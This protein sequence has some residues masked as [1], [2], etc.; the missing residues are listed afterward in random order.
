MT[1]FYECIILGGY[2]WGRYGAWDGYGGHGWGGYGIRPYGGD[3]NDSV[4]CF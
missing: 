3:F 2:G 4:N 1:T